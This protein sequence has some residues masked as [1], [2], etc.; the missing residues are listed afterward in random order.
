MLTEFA[1]HET[2]I[3]RYLDEYDSWISPPLG[4]LPW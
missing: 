1:S 2:T 3:R 4:W